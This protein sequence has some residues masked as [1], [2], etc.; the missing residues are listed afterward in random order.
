MFGPLGMEDSGFHVPENALSRL[1]EPFAVDPGMGEPIEL[2]DVS[3]RPANDS[4]GAGAVSTA[5]DYLRFA[6]MLLD[7]GELDGTRIL[8]PT[9][10]RLMTS[11]HL[12]DAINYGVGPGPLLIGTPGYTFG[13]GFGVREEQGIAAVPG[14]A[15]EFMWAG[16]GGTYFWV[17]PEEG[18]A[19]VLMTQR[20]GPTRAYYRRHIKQL[21][22]QSI[23]DTP[24]QQLAAE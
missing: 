6:Q 8:S 9:T 15:G 12:G 17:D 14:S 16:Y 3:Q 18:L 10:I 4:G 21:V 23:V 20:A 7:G 11:D 24:D 2:M 1:A 5:S 13:L 22:Y 19:A